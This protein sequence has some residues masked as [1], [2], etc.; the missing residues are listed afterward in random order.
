VTTL[1]RIDERREPVESAA[2]VVDGLAV[3]KAIGYVP[4][5]IS[6]DGA[7]TAYEHLEFWSF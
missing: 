1:A 4:Q 7:L 2:A 3:R 5:A 6:I